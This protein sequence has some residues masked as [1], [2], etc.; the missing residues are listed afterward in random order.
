MLDKGAHITAA[1][2]FLDDV[3]ARMHEHEDKRTPLL[4]R[5]SISDAFETL[6][7]PA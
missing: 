2:R 7:P 6:G 3:F 1:L 4:R 5:L